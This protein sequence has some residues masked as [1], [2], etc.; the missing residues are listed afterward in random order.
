MRP[1]CVSVPAHDIYN[2]VLDQPFFLQAKKSLGIVT[3]L[4]G[5]DTEAARQ[6]DKAGLIIVLL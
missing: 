5:A 6:L 2:G 3:R 4:I 1:L